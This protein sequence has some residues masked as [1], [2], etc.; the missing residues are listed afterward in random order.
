MAHKAALPHSAFVHAHKTARPLTEAE[1]LF[2]RRFLI[3]LAIVV[4]LAGLVLAAP[5][6]LGAVTAMGIFN[7]WDAPIDYD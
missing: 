5:A 6:A 1:R 3:A 4:V 2:W 7:G